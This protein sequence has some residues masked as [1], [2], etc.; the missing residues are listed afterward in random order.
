MVGGTAEP[1]EL[2]SND[3]VVVPE[4]RRFVYVL[5]EVTRPGRYAIG[6]GETLTATDALSVAGGLNSRGTNRRVALVRPNEEGVYTTRVFNIDEFLR[7]GDSDA[8]PVMRPGDVLF[9]GQPRGITLADLSRYIGPI[10]LI[11]TLFGR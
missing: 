1:F 11:D 2:Q 8:N 4:N 10:L 7:D 9:F 5:G 6:D 3:L